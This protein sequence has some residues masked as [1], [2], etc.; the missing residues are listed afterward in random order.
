MPSPSK[1]PRRGDFKNGLLKC[2]C[3]LKCTWLNKKLEKV[4]L[5]LHINYLLTSIL[6]THQ[7]SPLGDLGGFAL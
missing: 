3:I 5:N 4:E 6:Y 1:S 2:N 7:K